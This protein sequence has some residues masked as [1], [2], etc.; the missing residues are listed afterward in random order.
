LKTVVSDTS[1]LVAFAFLS[2][3]DLLPKLLGEILIPPTVAKEIEQ[4]R[5]GFSGVN[6]QSLPGVIVR[7]PADARLVAKLEEQIDAGEAESLALAVE[8][9]ADLVIVDDAAARHA[10]QGLG[11][12]VTGT[13]GL[14][15]RAKTDRHIT[16]VKP[17]LD[18]LRTD[19]RFFLAD[20]LYSRALAAAGE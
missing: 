8:V 7:Q 18:R 2:L 6:A 20:S 19:L 10:A 13:V 9:H 15:L 3:Q 16:A 14:L 1:P 11:L 17:I 12:T 4:P 5:Y